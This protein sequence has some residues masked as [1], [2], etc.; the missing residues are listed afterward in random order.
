MGI[1]YS[2]PRL[3][4]DGTLIYPKRGTSPPIPEGYQRKSEKSS[5]AW[6]M[7]PIWKNCSFRIRKQI[8]RKDCRCV[9]F[10]YSCGH[11]KCD[12]Q[13]LTTLMCK[14]CIFWQE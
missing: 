7:I 6:I 3:M 4:S 8:Q 10:I 11:P 14:S 13:Y 12:H 9:T 5:D 1:K 2:A